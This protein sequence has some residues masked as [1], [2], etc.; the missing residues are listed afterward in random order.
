MADLGDDEYG[1]LGEDP[2]APVR[3]RRERA[4]AALR[5][6]VSAARSAGEAGASFDASVAVKEKD[7]GSTAFKA[8]DFASA[9]AAYTLA[10]DNCPR[11]ARLLALGEQ[12]PPPASVDEEEGGASAVA[13][14]AAPAAVPLDA[15]AVAAVELLTTCLCN[16][17]AVYVR[18]EVGTWEEALLDCDVAVRLLHLLSGDSAVRKNLLPKALGRRAKAFESLHMWDDAL[19]GAS[20]AVGAHFGQS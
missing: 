1:G 6:D 13:E 3:E 5:S 10:I 16:R 2:A 14:P 8:N 12:P 7:R 20:A 4:Q 17:A 11:A 9:L 19:A 15:E 18:P